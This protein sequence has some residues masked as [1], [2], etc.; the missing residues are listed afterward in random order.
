M[1]Y[2]FM[3]V[4]EGESNDGKRELVTPPSRSLCINAILLQEA[5]LEMESYFGTI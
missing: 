5:N 3:S 2:P 1:L 4:H